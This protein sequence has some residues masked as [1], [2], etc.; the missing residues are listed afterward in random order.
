MGR[1][2]IRH[3]AICGHVLNIHVTPKGNF[4]KLIA[5]FGKVDSAEYWECVDC[6]NNQYHEKFVR[7]SDLEIQAAPD[8]YRVRKDGLGYYFYKQGVII[9]DHHLRYVLAEVPQ[10]KDDELFDWYVESIVHIG[11][12]EFLHYIFDFVE[13]M[14]F[15]FTDDD[16]KI[17]EIVISNLTQ[18]IEQMMVDGVQLQDIQLEAA[19]VY[20]QIDGVKVSEN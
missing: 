13:Y 8:R 15:G 9:V 14:E 3:C 6:F 7:S 20:T 4:S 18:Y 17:E 19:L 1:F 12:H 16:E 10:L 2:Y 11:F 5:Y